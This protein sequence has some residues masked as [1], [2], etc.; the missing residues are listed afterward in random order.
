MTT[1]KEDKV[2]IIRKDK[3]PY[4]MQWTIQIK[5]ATDLRTIGDNSAYMRRVDMLVSSLLKENRDEVRGYQ[6]EL[7]EASRKEIGDISSIKHTLQIYDL[8]LEK[9]IDVL[10]E[11]NFLTKTIITNLGTDSME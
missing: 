2:E 10:E 7:R 11:A 1:S 3:I 6:Q 4:A 8:T 9:V 5:S